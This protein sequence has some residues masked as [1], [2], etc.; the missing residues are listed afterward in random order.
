M[1][2]ECLVHTKLRNLDGSAFHAFGPVTVM[3]LSAKRRRVLGTMKTPWA[4][5]RRRLSVQRLQSS[6]TYDYAVL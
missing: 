5:K 3:D 1:S 2:S 4:T 6:I